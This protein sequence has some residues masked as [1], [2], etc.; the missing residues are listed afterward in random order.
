MT[1]ILIRTYCR[2]FEYFMGA[3]EEYTHFRWMF[4]GFSTRLGGRRI[5]RSGGVVVI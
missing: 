4:L 2:T 5:L 1:T 3:Y